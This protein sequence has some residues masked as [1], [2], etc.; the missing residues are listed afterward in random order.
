MPRW[1]SKSYLIFTF[2][3]IQQTANFHHSFQIFASFSG[4]K[5]FIFTKVPNV[6]SRYGSKSVS[7]DAICRICIP[8]AWMSALCDHGFKSWLPPRQ[9]SWMKSAM[10]LGNTVLSENSI[11]WSSP[12]WL[13]FYMQFQNTNDKMF[14][15]V[16]TF[17]SV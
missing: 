2:Y 16:A 5:L 17:V 1:E 7:K 9:S 11:L 10:N 15:I 13:K 12:V 4:G 6:R 8:V 3:L 14:E